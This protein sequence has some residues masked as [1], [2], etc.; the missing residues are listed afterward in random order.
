MKFLDFSLGLIALLMLAFALD[1]LR[2]FLARRSGLLPPE[3][4][5]T[6]NDVKRLARAGQRIYAI[7]CYREIHG[8]KLAEAKRAVEELRRA[9]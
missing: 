9:S 1:L 7:R 3:G 6:M 4:R 2:D 5:A 8:C